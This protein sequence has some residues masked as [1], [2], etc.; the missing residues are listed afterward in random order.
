MSE[1]DK[2]ATVPSVDDVVLLPCPCCG[3]ST[4]SGCY[5]DG[6]GDEWWV[7]CSRCELSLGNRKSEQAAREAWNKRRSDGLRNWLKAEL[8][9]ARESYDPC[10]WKDCAIYEAAL[11]QAKKLLDV[12][13]GQ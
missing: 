1:Q 5:D 4:N 8:A 13:V 3:G 11:K 9:K 2:P 12:P 7:E 10:D 6:G